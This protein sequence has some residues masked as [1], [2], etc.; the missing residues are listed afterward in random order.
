M[1]SGQQL[2]QRTVA[3]AELEAQPCE[4]C[5]ASKA[6]AHHDD[7]NRPLVVRWL[8]RSCHVGQPH[9]NYGYR[10]YKPIKIGSDVDEWLHRLQK[11]WH[12]GSHNKVL[13]R[14]LGL[15]KKD[16]AKRKLAGAS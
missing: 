3:T 5:G 12:L 7:Y 2:A 4:E 9:K 8:C 14:L 1:R 6:V 11:K 10:G 13:R 16:A 15:S